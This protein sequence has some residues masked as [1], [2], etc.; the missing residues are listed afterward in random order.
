MEDEYEA[1]IPEKKHRVPNF[2]Q[3]FAPVL[4]VSTNP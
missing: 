3:L 4:M 1:H 2:E